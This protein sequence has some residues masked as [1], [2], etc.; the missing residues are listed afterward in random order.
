MDYYCCLLVL[1]LDIGLLLVLSFMVAM[2]DAFLVKLNCHHLSLNV[3]TKWSTP[4]VKIT[5]SLNRYCFVSYYKCTVLIDPDTHTYSYRSTFIRSEASNYHTFTHTWRRGSYFH[6]YTH[7]H[8]LPTHI[9]IRRG[10][11]FLSLHTTHSHTLPPHTPFPHT[12]PRPHTQEERFLFPIY[13]LF[14][15]NAAVALAILPVSAN[16]SHYF[17]C[18]ISLYHGHCCC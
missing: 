5:T 16:G 15:L 18:A 13:P 7:S 14:C 2:H 9:R 11:C 1:L 3:Y 17:S 12:T 4:S 8:P 10:S 6:L